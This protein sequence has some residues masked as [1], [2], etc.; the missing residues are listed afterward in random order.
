MTKATAVTAIIT[1]IAWRNLAKSIL[2]IRMGFPRAWAGVRA[3][4]TQ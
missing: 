3:G 2:I 4:D 1:R